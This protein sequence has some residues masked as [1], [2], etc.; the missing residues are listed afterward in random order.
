VRLH[1]QVLHPD[2]VTPSFD[3]Y[4][5]QICSAIKQHWPAARP[6][7][8]LI[9]EAGRALIDAAGYLIT[10]VVAVKSPPRL[11]QLPSSVAYGKHG[12]AWSSLPEVSQAVVVDSGVHLLY[13]SAWLAPT[14]H[15][16]RP[17]LTPPRAT[18][19]YG[20]LCMNI[21]RLREQAPLPVLAAGDPLVLHPVGAYNL[22]QWMQFITYRPAVVLIDLQG[23]SHCIRRAETLA[24]VEGPEQLPDYLHPTAPDPVLD[25]GRTAPDPA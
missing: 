21:D 22:S 5:Q 14:I 16:A 4:A 24:D 9:L 3:D 13:T 11:P 6:L 17:P 19:V 7:P 18:A 20:C 23:H 15:T 25:P 1:G 12:A 2:Q 8:R 10:S